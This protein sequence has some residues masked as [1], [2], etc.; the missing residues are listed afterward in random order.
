MQEEITNT[1]N[2]MKA[3]L[4]KEIA[5]HAE[6][7]RQLEDLLSRVEDIR[8]QV[9]E[10]AKKK[11]NNNNKKGKKEEKKSSVLFFAITCM[12][13]LSLRANSVK[14][15]SEFYCILLHCRLSL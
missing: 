13:T 15:H 6:T 11:S 4:D 7:R 8:S 12:F 3:R 14:D 9:T 1:M 5:G 2:L 10:K